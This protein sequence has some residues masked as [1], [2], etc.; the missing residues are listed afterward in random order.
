VSALGDLARPGD[1]ERL[2]LLSGMIRLAERLELSRDRSIA[3]VR[4]AVDDGK[5]VLETETSPHSDPSVPIW[6]AR[7]EA[8][9]LAGAL[10]KPVEIAGE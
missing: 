9:L 5:V 10:S 1:V 2:R 4:V 6:A 3:A 8:G 7:R